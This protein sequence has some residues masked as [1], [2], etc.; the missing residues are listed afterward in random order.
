VDLSLLRIIQIIIAIRITATH[1][2]TGLNIARDAVIEQLKIF[3]NAYAGNMKIVDFFLFP[4]IMNEL[5]G[6]TDR[7]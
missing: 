7:Q 1:K 6:F 2:A 5:H 3:A 4:V